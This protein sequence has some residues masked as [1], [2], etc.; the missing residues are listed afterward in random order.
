VSSETHGRVG[1]IGDPVGHSLSPAFQ[2]AAFDALGIPT[3]YELLHTPPDE[4][5]QRL[6]DLRGGEFTGANVTVPHKEAFFAAV[7]ARSE[8]AERVG[9]VNTIVCTDGRLYGDNTD[10][11]GFAQSLF[12]IDFEFN[13][14]R[15][16]ILGAGGASRAAVVALLENGIGEVVIANR[17]IERARK[18]SSD[19]EDARLVPVLLSEVGRHLPGIQL[20]VNATAVGWQG[21]DLP[22]DRAAFDLL[23]AGTVAY[24]LTYR[25]TPFLAAARQNNLTAVDGLAM[26]VHQG[27]RS[28]ELW[29]GCEAPLDVMW[30]AALAARR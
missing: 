20:I 28:F 8:V 6:A 1:L 25:S 14:K 12:D 26:L 22:M 19:L 3:R 9:A 15:A 13:G 7:D 29:I 24:D 21:D 17:S 27:A 30:K 2:Q 5:H 18:L 11:H 4:I 16:V 23:G 10:V